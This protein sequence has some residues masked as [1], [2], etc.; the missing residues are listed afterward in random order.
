MLS[1]FD[2]HAPAFF[3]ATE[4]LI[5]IPSQHD[6]VDQRLLIPIPAIPSVASPLA[7]LHHTFHLLKCINIA[8][9]DESMSRGASR[10]VEPVVIQGKERH[11]LPLSYAPVGTLTSDRSAGS[12][13]TPEAEKNNI[14]MIVAF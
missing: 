13:T 12:A 6:P 2:L 9:S 11:G 5:N 3:S 14:N 4:R 8:F 10:H 7:P 1:S